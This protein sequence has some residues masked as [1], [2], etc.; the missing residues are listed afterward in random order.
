MNKNRIIAE[1]K[2]HFFLS[3]LGGTT[4]VIFFFGL[5]QI[6]CEIATYYGTHMEQYLLPHNR[7]YPLI[8]FLLFLFLVKLILL[9]VR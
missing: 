8:F 1:N 2:T 3:G 7:C 9:I 4:A 5:N 6:L